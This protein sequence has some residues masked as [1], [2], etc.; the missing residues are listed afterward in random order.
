MNWLGRSMKRYEFPPPWSL[1]VL[2]DSD[3][4]TAYEFDGY[5]LDP[6]RRS[7]TQAD[8]GGV[9]LTG[10]PFDTLVYLVEHAGEVV[11]RDALVHAVWPRRVVEDN[12]LNQAIA[13]LRRLLGEQHIVTVAG[14]GYQFVTPVRAVVVE[15]A[16]ATGPRAEQSAQ[17]PP[18]PVSRPRFA[19]LYTVPALA[20]LAVALIALDRDGYAPRSTTGRI[21]VLPCDDLS[22]DPNDSHFAAGIH[23]E[24][25]N[26]LV[27]IRSLRVISRSSVMQY[28]DNRPPIPQ[29]GADLGVETIMECGVRYN[30]DRVML[31]VQLI[32]VATDEHLWSQSY[33]GDMSDLR[34]LYE[35]QA[36]IATN[37]AHALRVEFFDEELAQ[38]KQAPTD[39][40]EAHEFYLASVGAPTIERKIEL[41]EQAL[42]LDPEFVDAWLQKA[43]FHILY[44]GF[45]TGEE[46]TAAH[47][48][49]LEA[50]NRALVLDPNSGEAHALL[51][52]YHGQ[53]GD[54]MSSEV[55]WRRAIELGGVPVDVGHYLVMMAVGHVADA[56][57][58]MEAGLVQDPM[59]QLGRSMLLLAYEVIDKKDERHRHWKR[60]EELFGPW[61]GD[62]YESILRILE[63][64]KEFL[65]TEVPREVADFYGAVWREGVGNLDSPADG[66]AAMRSLHANPELRTGENLRLMTVWA[67]HFGEPPLALQWFRE[68]L[69]LQATGMLHAWLPAFE[70]LRREPGFK[71]LVR[72]QGLPEYWNTYG[73]PEFCRRTEGDDFECD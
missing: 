36:D 11:D 62:F 35:I 57:T 48:A 46:S 2:S 18:S 72:D 26:R 4:S 71:D 16:E 49:A 69:E 53:L 15:P 68:S 19:W 14:R 70:D 25:L 1:P 41:L 40:H 28:A 12:N 29:I 58:L 64:D 32:D 21:A 8:G 27:Q 56:V 3:S 17:A 59:D 55:A 10:R 65:R 39:S 31:T 33:P 42:E 44:A 38:I 34:A 47:A 45:M 54:W 13:V 52:V 60:G 20:V 24:L 43:F 22:P 73:W 30:G 51:A 67:L 61:A 9:K 6:A 23:D 66:L 50:A 5:R 37:V 63:H 7:L